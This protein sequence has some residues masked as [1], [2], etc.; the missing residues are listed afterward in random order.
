VK[1]ENKQNAPVQDDEITVESLQL[2][3]LKAMCINTD[4]AHTQGQT[5]NS[6]RKLEEGVAWQEQAGSGDGGDGCTTT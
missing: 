4:A 5:S 3:S 6:K 1:T 2:Q